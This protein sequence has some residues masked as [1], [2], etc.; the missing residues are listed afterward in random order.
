VLLPPLAPTATTLIELTQYGAINVDV[1]GEVYET[2]M[3]P[4]LAKLIIII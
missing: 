1:V 2:V 3:S 4:A